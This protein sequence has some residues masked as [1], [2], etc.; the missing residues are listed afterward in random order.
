MIHCYQKFQSDWHPLFY[1]T[2]L[3]PG[4]L[5]SS[6]EEATQKALN[7]SLWPLTPI[8]T[9]PGRGLPVL[10]RTQSR[11]G[12]AFPQGRDML[13]HDD[14]ALPSNAGSDSEATLP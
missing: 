8:F 13:T 7:C 5:F 10:G 4:P 11:G 6:A 3:K 2:T 1:L 12:Q 9:Q 14:R